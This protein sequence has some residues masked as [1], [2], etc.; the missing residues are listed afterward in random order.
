M[1]DSF[2]L[3]VTDA[4][5]LAFFLFVWG[6]Y[7]L[8]VEGR[9]F[10][11]TSLTRA[12]NV[13]REAWMRAMAKRELRMVDTSIMIG[14]QQGTAFFASTS[15][16]ALGGSLALLQQSDRVLVVL[17]DLPL[18]AQPV[19][20]VFEMKVLGLAVLMA[21]SFFKFAWSYRLFNYCSIL[22]GA[23]PAL[24]ENVDDKEIEQAEWRAARMNILAGKHFN[25]GLRGILFSIGYLGWFVGP[26]PF[27][28]ATILVLGVLIRRQFFSAARRTVLATGDQAGPGKS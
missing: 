16:I 12:M 4:L 2:P 23:V 19:R 17:A 9:L 6:F 24:G 27:V 25:T 10:G 15:L 1:V 5:A 22:I 3:A 14:L 8:A 26:G 28:I 7:A 21:Y 11:R 18:V 20:G 13:Q